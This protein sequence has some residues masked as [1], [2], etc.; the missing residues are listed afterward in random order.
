MIE[1]G[2]HRITSTL[3]TA[4][5]PKCNPQSAQR[6]V[7]AR[8]RPNPPSAVRNMQNRFRRSSLELRGPKSGL[9]IDPQSSG[10]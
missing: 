6:P 9:K 10:G 7:G 5:R 4:R 2:K 1:A 8:I 3:Y